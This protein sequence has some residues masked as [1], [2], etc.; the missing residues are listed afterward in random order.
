MPRIALSEPEIR[1]YYESR[2]PKLRQSGKELR[3]PCPIHKGMRDS[4]AINLETGTWFC[5]S[6][7]AR[8]GSIFDF[9]AELSGTNGKTARAAVLAAVGRSEPERRI[10]ATYD[11]IDENGKLLYQTV[12]YLPKDFRQRRPDGRGGWVWNLKGVRLVPYRLPAVLAAPIVFIAEGEKDVDAL[13]DL[14]VVATC[15]PMGAGKWKSKYST[16]LRGKQQVIVVPDAD[17]KGRAHAAGVMQSV[18]AVAT[19]VK[20]LELPGAKDAAEWIE[21]G[22]TLDALVALVE[23]EEA[24]AGPPAAVI[25]LA[26]VIEVFKKWLHLPDTSALKVTLGAVAANLLEGDALWLLLVGATGSGKTEYLDALL[27]LPYNM[28]PVGTLT[29]ASLLSGSPSREKA[30]DATGGL[31]RSIGDFGFLLLKDFTSVLAMSGEIRQSVLAALREIHDGHWTRH[32]GTDGGR[33][34]SWSGKCA[35]IGGCTPAIDLHHQ[36][37]AMMGERFVLVRIPSTDGEK[38]ADSAMEHIGRERKMREELRSAVCALFK[39]IGTRVAFE[40]DEAARKRMAALASFVAHA[41]SAV[42]RDRYHRDIELIPGTEMPGRL[43]VTLRRL[44]HGLEVIGVS[45][46]ECW[47]LV[48]RV[49]LDCIPDVRRKVLTCLWQQSES[50]KKSEESEEFALS[51]EIETLAVAGAISYPETTTRRVLED[52]TGHRLVQRF[53]KLKDRVKGECHVWRISSLSK[54]LLNRAQVS[55]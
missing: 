44:F 25:G 34:L 49:G 52:L 33:K 23:R 26:G 3:G 19:P 1:R 40:F 18:G 54:E 31:L 5:H 4:L 36:V 32:M 17:E 7:C 46:E 41:R 13:T 48:A 15:N 42:E 47:K 39:S 37:M 10:V 22:G 2:I 51:E 14:G 21:R 11:Y 45:R 29:E 16:F 30:A 38:Q 43:A 53:T 27:D 8:G 6:G 28:H 35:L 12:R 24:G 55:L 50:S 9:E 20:L